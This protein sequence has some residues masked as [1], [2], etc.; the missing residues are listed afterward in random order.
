MYLNALLVVLGASAGYAVLAVVMLSLS[1]ESSS[2]F[3]AAGFA[4]AGLLVLTSPFLLAFVPLLVQ[5]QLLSATALLDS[6]LPTSASQFTAG[7][8][9]QAAVTKQR[10]CS[11]SIFRLR[12]SA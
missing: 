5:V 10:F 1:P 11:K 2:A 8:Q 9:S 12:I 6:D 3:Q 4:T 7:L